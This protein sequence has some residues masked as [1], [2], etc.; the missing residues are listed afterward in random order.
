MGN[1]QQ[2]AIPVTSQFIALAVATWDLVLDE[3]RGDRIIGKNGSRIRSTA[4]GNA[5]IQKE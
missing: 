3:Q 4:E 2:R 5:A 1:H